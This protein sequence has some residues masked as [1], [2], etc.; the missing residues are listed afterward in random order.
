[1]EAHMYICVCSRKVL[2]VLRLQAVESVYVCTVLSGKDL[3][4]ADVCM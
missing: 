3:L 4:S 2:A 1:M